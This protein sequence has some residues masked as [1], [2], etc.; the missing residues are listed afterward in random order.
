M[1]RAL[2]QRGLEVVYLGDPQEKETWLHKLMAYGEKLRSV[3]KLSLP[4]AQQRQRFA[5]HVRQ[6][7]SQLPCDVIFAPIASTEV[8]AIESETPLVYLSDAT[9]KLFHD[10]YLR[11]YSAGIQ[12]EVDDAA[13]EQAEHNEVVAISKADH[14]VYPSAWAARSAIQDYGADRSKVTIIPMGANLEHPPTAEEV[15]ARRRAPSP[16]EPLRLLFVGLHWQ[17]KGG[18][19]AFETLLSLLDRGINAE[20]TIVGCVPPIEHPKMT[21]IPFLN[22][23]S[24][25]QQQQLDEL[26]WQAHL[27][28]LPTRAE[29]FGMVLCEAGAFGLPVLATEVGGIP[30]II[31][32]GLN[33]YML[34]VE[35]GGEAYAS[36]ASE[37]RNDP[38]RYEQMVQASREEYDQ[39]LNWGSWADRM[40][41]VLSS[42]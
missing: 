35:A 28:I 34:P 5:Q 13:L 32:D 1:Q 24:P 2:K 10:E 3:L 4:E 21:V 6:Q 42:L 37:L 41:T 17:R 22:K 23:N 29:C 30:S 15:L 39:R 9:A 12:V 31:T 25:R 26:F 14:L 38:L 11:D 18:S 7:L 40:K 16:D 8:M 27:F 33:G 20:L 19:I 36:I